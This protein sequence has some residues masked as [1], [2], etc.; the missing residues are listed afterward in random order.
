M[1]K[2]MMISFS[3]RAS[4]CKNQTGHTYM[5]ELF[6][7]LAYFEISPLMFSLVL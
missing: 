6:N 3:Y 5:E 2:P 4:R 1:S 7:I